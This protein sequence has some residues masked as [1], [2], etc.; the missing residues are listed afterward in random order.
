M[1]ASNTLEPDNFAPDFSIDD[2]FDSDD[3]LPLPDAIS[4]GETEASADAGAR[5]WWS[6]RTASYDDADEGAGAPGWLSNFAKNYGQMWLRY[7]LTALFFGVVCNG[8]FGIP[9][10]QVVDVN[11][12]LLLTWIA[13]VGALLVFILALE[14]FNGEFRDGLVTLLYLAAFTFLPFGAITGYMVYG[15][16]GGGPVSEASF[17]YEGFMSIFTT[18]Y[19]YISGVF[20]DVFGAI[21]IKETAQGAISTIN[22][23]TLLKWSQIIP[24]AIAVIEFVLRRRVPREQP[25]ARR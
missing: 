2:T 1:P 15:W 23:D 16:L 24:P 12:A 7:A 18:G 4:G 5:S 13:F 11:L 21:E 25:I 9:L 8:I 3:L 22:S 6:W 19:K 14:I 20:G 10:Y 17:V